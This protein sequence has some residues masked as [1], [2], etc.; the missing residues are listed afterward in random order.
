MKL[1]PASRFLTEELLS[2]PYLDGH[3]SMEDGFFPT[4]PPLTRFPA[5]HDAWNQA[6]ARLPE[7]IKRADF[8]KAFIETLPLLSADAENLPDEYLP[9][10]ATLLAVLAHAFWNCRAGEK[11]ELPENIKRPWQEVSHRLGRDSLNMDTVDLF[12]NNWRFIDETLPADERVRIENMDVAVPTF[13]NP[14]ERVFYLTFVEMTHRSRKLVAAA[15]R[16]QDAVV[17]QDNQELKLALVEILGLLD[18]LAAG[19]LKA[20]L[21]PQSET[22]LDPLVLTKTTSFFGVPSKEATSTVSGAFSPI[23]L[24]L[25]ILLG[26][27]QFNSDIGQQIRDGFSHIPQVYQAYFARVA[28][29]SISQYVASSD[30]EELRSLFSQV[31]ER[32][33]G[34][35]GLL[36][37]HRDK[38]AYGVLNI[39][40]RI[41]R[42]ETVA[43][44]VTKQTKPWV[45][46]ADE[47]DAAMGERPTADTAT[48]VQRHQVQSQPGS[49]MHAVQLH[50]PAYVYHKPGDHIEIQPENTQDQ[51]SKVLA[52][53]DRVSHEPVLLTTPWRDFF[54]KQLRKEPDGLTLEQCLRYGNIST[55][56]E[57]HIRQVLPEL[58]ADQENLHRKFQLTDLLIHVMQTQPQKFP[59]VMQHLTELVQP[60]APRS[61]SISSVSNYDARAP[62]CPFAVDL[63][64]AAATYDYKGLSASQTA[65]GVGSHFLTQPSPTAEQAQTLVRIHP[66]HRFR[67]PENKERPVVMIAMGS[68]IA[69][70]KS[71]Y[72]LNAAHRENRPM[73]LFYGV[74]TMA[75]VPEPTELDAIQRVSP[76]CYTIAASREGERKRITQVMREQHSAYLR[77]MLEGDACFYICG[78]SQFVADVQAMFIDI[79]AEKFA[80]AT[81]PHEAAKHYFYQHVLSKRFFAQ[82]F[83]AE[84]A[85]VKTYPTLSVADVS[86]HNDNEHGYWL[87]IHNQVYDMTDYQLAHP[88]GQHLIRVNAGIDATE[89]FDGVH[90]HRDSAAAMHLAQRYKVGELLSPRFEREDHQ[91]AYEQ[92]SALLTTV[93]AYQNLLV[94]DYFLYERNNVY[95]LL[96]SLEAH[97]HFLHFAEKSLLPQ[98]ESAR[99]CL[100]EVFTADEASLPAAAPAS[101]DFPYQRDKFGEIISDAESDEVVTRLDSFRSMMLSEDQSL[102]RKIKETTIAALNKLLAKYDVSPA[103]REASVRYT[104]RH[105]F[106]GHG[107]PARAAEQAATPVCPHM[108]KQQPSVAM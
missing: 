8:R 55:I 70:L 63:S 107:A 16:A 34:K 14:A 102:L 83:S 10:A 33:A 26:R 42:I 27:K 59:L 9:L 103:S 108:T 58:L 75:D 7:A 88:G 67:L 86:Q 100:A 65:A 73:H 44:L 18:N 41:G 60:L 71:F 98:M 91:R 92:L 49:A 29:V 47:L 94:L 48:T 96:K 68:G 21:N 57:D 77:D 15:S 45:K 11:P 25:D 13:A 79:L 84:E 2:H 72:R 101:P 37:V 38:A 74:R 87:T 4:R 66:A 106:L 95:W 64:V 43:G 97:Q 6:I 61:Y 19:F 17:N 69:P 20:D 51:I 23:F 31:L 35:S 36:S 93:T 80:E 56:S 5:S 32:Y 76:F 54:I 104:E 1:S 62:K 81:S 22:H 46:I 40:T 30:D 82:E 24:L 78:S 53:L 52:L 85:A 89:E 12:L 50:A 99:T 3:L 105:R 28:D 90:A 39:G